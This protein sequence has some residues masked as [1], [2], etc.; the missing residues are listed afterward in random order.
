MYPLF[1]LAFTCEIFKLLACAPLENNEV[2]FSIATSRNTT[3]HW[4]ALVCSMV[5]LLSFLILEDNQ[6]KLSMTTVEIK[7]V[8]EML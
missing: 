8:L 1:T 3:G 2:K 7:Q 5:F 6:L 4:N